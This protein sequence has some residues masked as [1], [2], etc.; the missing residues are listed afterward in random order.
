M[1]FPNEAEERRLARILDEARTGDR[2]AAARRI[3][4][5]DPDYAPAWMLLGAGSEDPVEGVAALWKALSMAPCRPTLYFALGERLTQISEGDAMAKRLRVLS[6]WKVS[7]ADEVPEVVAEHFAK[8]C[9]KVAREPEVYEVLARAADKEFAGENEPRE[10]TARLRPYRLLNELQRDGI[11]GLEEETLTA[12]RDHAEECEPL[13]RAALRE[14]GRNED[15]L[16]DDTACLLIAILG[17]ISGADAVDELLELS[18]CGDQGIFAHT[19]WA[20]CRLAERHRAGVMERYGAALATASVKRRCAIADQI[21]LLEPDPADMPVLRALAGGFDAI[22]Q[23]EEAPFV[24]ACVVQC[25]VKRGENALASELAKRTKGFAGGTREIVRMALRGEFV[26]ALD[27]EDLTDLSIEDV[28]LA[29][30]LL[31]DEPL[32]EGDED[33][34]EGDEDLDEGDEE[35]DGEEIDDI[36]EPAP[37]PRPGRNDLCWCGSG[38]KYKKCHLAADEESDRSARERE[39][40]EEEDGGGYQ[41]APTAHNLM[42]MRVLEGARE[43]VSMREMEQA[44]KMYFGRKG[45]VEAEQFEIESF[46]AWLLHDFRPSSTGRTPMEAYLESHGAALPPAERALLESLREARFGLYEVER[47]EPGSG[48]HLHDLFGGDRM[49][50]HDV[51]TS[52]SVARWDCLLTRIQFY[53]GRWIFPGNGTTLPRNLLEQFRAMVEEGSREAKQMPAEFVRANSHRL[54]RDV[55]EMYDRSMANIRF[56]NREGEDVTFGKAE[57]EI[58]DE[59]RLTAALRAVEELE[60]GDAKPGENPWF[61]WI[62]QLGGEKRP[63]G[64]VEIDGGELRLEAMSR[65]RLQT[66]RGLIETHVRD[67]V[68]HRGDRYRTIEEAKEELKQSGRAAEPKAVV[69]PEARAAVARF[70]GAHYAHWA[71]EHLPALGGKT[72]RQSLRTKAGRQAVIDLL[73]MME[74]G[75]QHKARNGDPAYDFNIVRRDLGLEEE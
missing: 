51:S 12:I 60:E 20:L 47:I 28:C 21:H 57:Y 53:E 71:D 66:L 62:P 27:E 55:K 31:E 54:H 69:S 64:H 15:A 63:M 36:F 73:R 5:T 33:L 7:F 10:I 14:W 68:R 2:V 74:N 45:K 11:N 22:R 37:P 50:L 3:T 9:G 61:T 4:Q 17:E 38:K 56:V 65:T 42:L 58:L 25:L 48:V 67:L 13:L 52:N 8:L 34:D 19:H 44:K 26:S 41:P 24:A 16:H 70:I 32:D 29:R 39:E 1:I 23:D 49:F 75:E 59:S 30:I 18:S 35:F 40:D 6:L 72:P 43:S 46:V